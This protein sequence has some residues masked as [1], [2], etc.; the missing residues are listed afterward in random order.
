MNSRAVELSRWLQWALLITAAAVMAHAIQTVRGVAWGVPPWEPPRRRA[1]TA[2]AVRPLDLTKLALRLGMP[3]PP[4][5]PNAFPPATEDA[6]TALPLRL[7]GR[8]APRPRI[9]HWR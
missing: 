9:I 4:E 7:L 8:R 5:P 6:V 2:P 3:L 1:S